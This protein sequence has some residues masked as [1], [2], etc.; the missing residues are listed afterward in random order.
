MFK[1]KIST[2]VIILVTLVLAGVAIFTAIRLYQLRSQPVVPNVPSS[3]PGAQEVTPPPV[4]A[5]CS[6]SFTLNAS[7]TPSPSASPT[8]SPTGSPTATP[9]PTYTPGAPNACG[10]TCGSNFNCQSNLVCYN[11]FCRN[12]SCTS[13]TN[14][15][16]GT[17]TATPAAAAPSLPQ[18]GTS[19]PTILGTGVGILVI[20]G[21]LLL[22]L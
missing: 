7:P 6:L 3:F 5:A 17:S 1:G 14:C 16:C 15:A 8:A 9:T 20:F 10:G 13:S 11:G 2:V 4:A 18:S 12:P 21:S 22:A 19:W